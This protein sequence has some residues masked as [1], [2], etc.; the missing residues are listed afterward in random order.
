[1][2]IDL[3]RSAIAGYDCDVDREPAVAVRRAVAL[4][5]TLGGDEALEAGGLGVKRLSELTGNEISRVSRTLEVLSEAGLVDRDQAS[6]AYR[7]GWRFFALASRAG[8]LQLRR[9]APGFVRLLTDEFGE[10]AYLSVLEGYEVLTVFSESSTHTVQAAGWLGRSHPYPYCTSAGRVLLF[11]HSEEELTALLGD[12][13]FR[14]PGRRGRP[15][16]PI[17]PRGLRASGVKVGSTW[18]KSSNPAWSVSRRRCSIWMATSL[19]PSTSRARSF[20]QEGL[21]QPRDPVSSKSP[22]SFRASL[23]IGHAH[24]TQ[25]AWRVADPES[26]RFFSDGQRLDGELFR[27]TSSTFMRS[28]LLA[29]AI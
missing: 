2:K 12:L 22:R 3:R 1:M 24:T 28:S 25:R 20:V 10:S 7:L 14:P 11:G 17:S 6:R 4:L 27:P 16:S 29:R 5:L 15:V 18:T 26:I 23:D 21:W 8:Q 9:A 19:P 13:E